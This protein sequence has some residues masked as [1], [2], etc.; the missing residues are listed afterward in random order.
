MSKKVQG[1]GWRESPKGNRVSTEDEF[2][3]LFALWLSMM[4]GLFN[5]VPNIATGAS[6]PSSLLT[7]DLGLGRSEEVNVLERCTA[8]AISGCLQ[9]GEPGIWE[10]GRP[11][12]HP[13]PLLNVALRDYYSLGNK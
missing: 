1:W 2:C 11:T 13:I 9:E 3:L 7:S 5:P 4:C 10:E 8:A 12:F 6:E